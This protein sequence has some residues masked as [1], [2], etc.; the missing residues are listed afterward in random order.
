MEKQVGCVDYLLTPSL[1]SRLLFLPTATQ[2]LCVSSPPSLYLSISIQ[3]CRD[4]YRYLYINVQLKKK[5]VR[6]LIVTNSVCCL[7]YFV[8]ISAFL[9]TAGLLILSVSLEVILWWLCSLQEPKQMLIKIQAGFKEVV[10]SL[11]QYLVITLCK[12]LIISVHPP[13]QF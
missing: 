8:F 6:I 2:H 4:L 7:F 1:S 11:I 13:P 3:I 5:F 12:V 10:G 9:N